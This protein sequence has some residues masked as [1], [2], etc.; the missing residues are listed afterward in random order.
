MDGVEESYVAS[1]TPVVA[2]GAVGFTVTVGI[3]MTGTMLDVKATVSA[4]RRYV[5]LDLRPEIAS[6]VS[7]LVVQEGAT[8][9][10]FTGAG[11]GSGG[12]TVTAG[13]AIGNIQLPTI[14]I[15]EARTSVSVPD[16][17]TLLVGGSKIYQ[18]S[19]VESGVPILSDIPVLKRL[20]N[21]RA[22]D[23]GSE[24]LLI[25]VK[26]TIII[27][28]EKEAELGLEEFTQ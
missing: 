20:F 12:T 24:T 2:E 6:L 26:P 4:D 18:Q 17:G 19:D 15:T 1:L 10:G 22:S 7:M 27:Q 25:L 21:N 23:K 16:G 8:A 11:T 3:L 13:S 14:K 9:G 5:Q 28:S